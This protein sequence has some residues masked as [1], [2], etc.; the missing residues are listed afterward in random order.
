MALTALPAFLLLVEQRI[1]EAVARGEFDNL[2][3]AGRPL[4]L[5]DDPMV[6]EEERLAIRIL[7]NAGCV[8]PEVERLAEIERLIA[9]AGER[10]DR[11]DPA[12]CAAAGKRLRALVGRL[13][14]VGRP[15]TAARAWSDYEA[16]MARRLVGPRR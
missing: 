11:D 12:V 3:G 1:A 13:E 5:D 15:A 4:D 2:P 14:A 6:P 9:T 16:A 7:K 10:P 8:P